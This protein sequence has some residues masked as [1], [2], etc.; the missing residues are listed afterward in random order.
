MTP[1]QFI[2][3]WKDATL[4]ERSAAQEHFIDLCRLLDEPTPAEADPTGSRYCFEKGAAKAG[5][6][7]GWADVWKRACF[8]WEYKGK[9]KDLKEAFKQLQIYTPALEY[10]PLLIV[11]DLD[12]I[13]IHTAFT[14]TVPDVHVL[15]LED[16][17][18][19][20]KRRLLKWAF[21]E[22]EQ[23]RPGQTTAALTEA[24]AGS[25]GGL[26]QR[27]RARGHDPWAVGH[28]CIRLLFCLFAEDIELL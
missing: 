22:P 13:V 21:T 27:L 11:S 25:F 2:A 7:D 14:G 19:A 8:G 3:K 5:G 20:A 12:R 28:F 10:P 16:L 18:D 23:L 9:G 26:A 24:A 17:R 6:G 15:T 1:D 4:K